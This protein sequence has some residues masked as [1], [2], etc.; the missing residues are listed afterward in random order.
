MIGLIWITL[1]QANTPQT[2]IH[3][4]RMRPKIVFLI[5]FV[6]L[7]FLAIIALIS[8]GFDRQP[9]TSETPTIEKVQPAQAIDSQ[10]SLERNVLLDPALEHSSRATV[11]PQGE[12][13]PNELIIAPPAVIRSAGAE[14]SAADLRRRKAEINDLSM[15]EDRESL[16][17]LLTEMQNPNKQIRAAALEGVIQFD[18]RTSIPQL[19]EIARQTEDA[20]EKTEILAAINYIKLPSLFEYYEERKAFRAEAGITEKKPSVF[21]K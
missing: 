19:K 3:P 7:G 21:R 20:T 18:D 1:D 14:L 2:T 13:F 16:N 9:E 10:E 11:A 4:I 8:N 17:T 12:S 6:G 15:R 5:L